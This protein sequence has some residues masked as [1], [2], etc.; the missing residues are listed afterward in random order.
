MLAQH[1]TVKEYDSFTRDKDISGSSYFK[2]SEY[3]F[4]QLERFILT[5]RSAYD[6]EALDLMSIGSRRGIGK[7]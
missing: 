6:T 2:L 7:I 5:N 4:D 1:Y 3:T